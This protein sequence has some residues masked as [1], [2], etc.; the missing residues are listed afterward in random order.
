MARQPGKLISDKA[1]LRYKPAHTP[2]QNPHPHPWRRRPCCCARLVSP[3]LPGPLR[4]SDRPITRLAAPLIH[5]PQGSRTLIDAPPYVATNYRKQ[6]VCDRW[7]TLG[8]GGYFESPGKALAPCTFPARQ[9]A[10]RASTLHATTRRKALQAPALPG[11]HRS[12]LR[13]NDIGIKAPLAY[14]PCLQQ[15]KHHPASELERSRD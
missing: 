3:Y 2:R 7:T 12:R 11:D 15:R 8:A 14:H 1:W 5:G 9:W 10:P 6:T 4:R 13:P